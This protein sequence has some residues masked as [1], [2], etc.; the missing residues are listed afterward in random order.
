MYNFDISVDIDLRE[1][2]QRTINGTDTTEPLST[3]MVLQSIQVDDKGNLA[4]SPYSYK[5]TGEAP[6]DKRHPNTTITGYKCAETL[7]RAYVVPFQLRYYAALQIADPGVDNESK[8]LFYLR[9]D[10]VIKQHDVFVSIEL[11]DDGNVVNP[12]TPIRDFV[13]LEVPPLSEVNGR[14]EFKIAIAKIIK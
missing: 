13:I 8:Y 1:E 12:V 7:E 3:Q 6:L 2:F 9:H 10:M 11:D 14:G 5:H 4:R